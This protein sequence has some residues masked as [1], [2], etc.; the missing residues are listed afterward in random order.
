MLAPC[1]SDCLLTAGLRG[2]EEGAWGC[3]E[4][5]S[6]ESLQ[7]NLERGTRGLANLSLTLG[8]CLHHNEASFHNPR[9]HLNLTNVDAVTALNIDAEWL[10]DEGDIGDQDGEGVSTSDE[11]LSDHIANR[12][13][14]SLVELVIECGQTFA[15]LEVAL[16]KSINGLF[17]RQ[18][19]VLPNLNLFFYENQLEKEALE[20]YKPGLDSAVAAGIAVLISSPKLGPEP[21]AW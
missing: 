3:R 14:R 10:F 7:K 16:A 17:K 9:A 1:K 18:T 8:A 21:M 4:A 15:P 13:P 20:P 5:W 2:I 19:E 12:L 6:P 11:H